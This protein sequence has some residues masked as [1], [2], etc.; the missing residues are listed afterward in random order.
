MDSFDLAPLVAMYSE[1]TKYKRNLIMV[2]ACSTPQ[3][4]LCAY[5]NR[6]TR[7]GVRQLNGRRLI[8]L[9]QPGLLRV[10]DAA[11]VEFVRQFFL[12][13]PPRA[14]PRT[15]QHGVLHSTEHF[16]PPFNAFTKEKTLWGG[17][18]LRFYLEL[19]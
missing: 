9:W 11:I 3:C 7:I 16:F 6:Y 19:I 13:K 2:R 17:R 8:Y 12:P 10:K 4:L 15:Q 18:I 14:K 5:P 1:K